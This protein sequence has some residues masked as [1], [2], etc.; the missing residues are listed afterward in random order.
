[1]KFTLNGQPMEFDG[2]PDLPLMNYLRE[3][4]GI[5]SPKD[6]C[7]PQAACGWQAETITTL[8]NKSP[9]KVCLSG[10]DN[11]IGAYRFISSGFSSDELFSS[12]SSFF[13]F[14]TFFSSLALTCLRSISTNSSSSPLRLT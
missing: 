11:H 1:M 8:K 3:Q 13:S 4:A 14:L 2:D 5:L 6:G 9:G 7:A 10:L 12:L